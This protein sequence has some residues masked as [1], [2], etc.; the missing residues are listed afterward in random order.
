M[1]KKFIKGLLAFL[2]FILGN[3][4]YTLTFKVIAYFLFIIAGCTILFAP[5]NICIF[6]F[7]LYLGVEG[8]AK[9]LSAYNPIIHV[10]A[11]I[12]IFSLWSR[13]GFR[14]ITRQAQIP[15]QFPPLTLLFIIH[16]CWFSITIL[17]PYSLSFLASL[18]G[19]KLY[20]TIISLYFFGYALAES[21]DQVRFFM[22][23]W[24]IVAFF[25]TGTSLYQASI[26]PSSV[27][28]ISPYYGYALEKLGNYA[29]RPFGLTSLPGLPSIFIYLAAPFLIYFI[30][31]SKN[32]WYALFLAAILPFSGITLFVCQIR[33][34]LLKS[35][36][37]IFSYFL[38]TLSRFPS[39]N[40]KTKKILLM[41]VPL[42]IGSLFI[43]GPFL[44]QQLLKQ[45]AD[46]QRAIERSLTL[47]D[48]NNV[49][50]ARDGALNR[51]L[52]YAKLAPLGAGLSRVGAAAGKFANLNE[53]D[54]NFPFTFFSDNLWV[55]L[56]VDLG[57][58]GTFIY[59]C[60]LVMI[61]FYGI[62]NYLRLQNEALKGI[63]GAI[64]CAL[65]AIFL[66]AYGAEPLLYNP[67]GSFFW[68]FSGVLMRL[69]SLDQSPTKDDLP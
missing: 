32:F 26:G 58:P 60:I 1:D 15:R 4:L 38:I 13:I 7:F 54:R 47:F 35:L 24:V 29:F 22:I 21:I 48:Y 65:I 9:L 23:P 6:I 14:L 66:G 40:H 39:L 43:T 19:M 37:G 8:F 27:L 52:T 42:C 18:A 30:F 56:V 16:F 3:V 51:F 61:F 20:V 53:V 11:D 34:A 36:F 55:E 67:E 68:F 63:Y 69:P 46:N 57:L 33:S 49:S 31:Y 64:L 12:F 25:Q 62:S 10:G 59:T 2:G 41:G 45:H 17:N 50:Q 5:M 44:T 28:S